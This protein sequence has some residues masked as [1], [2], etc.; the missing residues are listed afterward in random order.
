MGD[1]VDVNVFGAPDLSTH[2]RVDSTGDIN[3]ALA[4]IIHIAGLT[5]SDAEAVV[6][7]RLRDGG[8]MLNPHVTVF[9]KEYSAAG[10][11]VLGEVQHPGVYPILGPHHLW[12]LILAAGGM[13]DKAGNRVLLRHQGSDDATTVAISNDPEQALNSN[14]EIRAG[15][16]II[17]GRAGMVYVIGEVQ[18]SGGYTME[19]D[20]S[21][22][23]LGA[24]ARAR[25]PTQDAV[26]NRSRIVRKTAQGESVEIPLNLKD[27]LSAKQ[28]DVAMQDG[29]ILFIPGRRGKYAAQSGLNAVLGLAAAAA[30]HF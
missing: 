28:S 17:V 12:D 27:M 11:A 3:M 5:S 29:D 16:S 30:L 2:Q 1:E 8:F 6:E 22:T 24:L 10:V 7:K 21:I 25:G 18:Q 9:V 15:D 26:L 14:V 4:G 13:T 19:R 20:N 23:A